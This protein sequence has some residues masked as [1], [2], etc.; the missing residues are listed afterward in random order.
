MC[1]Y[2]I[3]VVIYTKI[4]HT[5]FLFQPPCLDGAFVKASRYSAVKLIAW[6][7]DCTPS[8]GCKINGLIT[9]ILN[10]DRFLYAV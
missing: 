8:L 1:V 4:I 9:Y 10:I 3:A 5:I 2:S 6:T 7:R